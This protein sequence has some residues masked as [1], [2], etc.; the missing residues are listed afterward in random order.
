M[1]LYFFRHALADHPNWSGPDT[2]RPLNEKGIRR[3]TRSAQTIQKLGLGLELI[4]SSPL[5]RARQTAE[6][7]IAKSNLDIPL[8]I[9]TRLAP[10][11]NLDDLAAIL[12][13]HPANNAIMLVGHEP[14]FSTVIS[15]LTGGSRLV[16][17]KGGLA[18]VDVLDHSPPRGELVWLIPPK[19]LDL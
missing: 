4:L 13:D 10:G 11:F 12:E 3:T 18:R 7:I 15:D 16:M 2:D 5:A 17:K 8:E 19:M 6:L 9:E 1:N 14:D